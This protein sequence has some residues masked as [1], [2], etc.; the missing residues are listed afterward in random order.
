MNKSQKANKEKYCRCHE[1]AFTE[2]GVCR[3]SKCWCLESRKEINQPQAE[4]IGFEPAW[5]G[6]NGKTK[7][8]YKVDG[9]KVSVRMETQAEALETADEIHKEWVDNMLDKPQSRRQCRCECHLGFQWQEI[10]G[11]CEHCSPPPREE[12]DWEKDLKVYLWGKRFDLRT[13]ADAEKR[14][15]MLMPFI[16]QLLHSQL[17]E[18]REKLTHILLLHREGDDDVWIKYDHVLQALDEMEEKK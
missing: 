3:K 12:R 15:T 2:C 18:V 13:T 6:S 5:K 16:N 11:E 8:Y 1:F 14:A 17:Q 4:E 10:N 9:K 7:G